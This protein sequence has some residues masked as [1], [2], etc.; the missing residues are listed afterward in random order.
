MVIK[1]CF[2]CKKREKG[3]EA[4]PD[5]WEKRILYSPLGSQWYG[6]DSSGFGLPRMIK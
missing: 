2:K 1:K 6:K 5:L 3:T 4:S